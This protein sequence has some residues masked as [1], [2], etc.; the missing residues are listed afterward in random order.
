MEV[1][2]VRLHDPI[3]ILHKLLDKVIMFKLQERFILF[4]SY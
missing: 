1:H 3:A 4:H 2:I